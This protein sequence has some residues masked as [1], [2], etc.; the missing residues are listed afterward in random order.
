[1]IPIPKRFQSTPSTQLIRN[2]NRKFFDKY[3][4]TYIPT[5]DIKSM[6]CT[7]LIDADS[8]TAIVG[9]TIT[10]TAKVEPLGI[11]DVN[12]NINGS[13]VNPVPIS[14][15]P[16]GIA[17]LPLDS[18][19]QP[20]GIY[21]MT[22]EVVSPSTCT[23]SVLKIALTTTPCTGITINNSSP[24]NA[25][26]GDIIHA[27]ATAT[28]AQPSIIEFAETTLGRFGS[29]IADPLT[30]ECTVDMDTIGAPPGTYSVVAKVGNG[31]LEQCVSTPVEAIL[32]EAPGKIIAV[33]IP[34]GARIWYDGTDTGITT[35]AIISNVTP[36]V[37]HTIEFKLSG[38]AVY[39]DTINIASGETDGEFIVLEPSTFPTETGDLHVTSTPNGVSFGL[40]TGGTGTAE[41]TLTG[42]PALVNAYEAG[43]T[44]Y[45]SALG[46]V[47]IKPGVITD[48]NIVLQPEIVN[49]GLAIFETIPMGADIYIDGLLTGAKTSYATFLAP[50]SHTYELRLEG[51]PTITGDF[52][53]VTGTDNPAIVSAVLRSE[54]SGI[55]M[56]AGVAVLGMMVLSPK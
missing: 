42:I 16:S 20:S 7:V 50:G 9:Q 15:D 6:Q 53:V 55:I 2:K 22:V 34:P 39:T 8:L 27:S 4:T 43:L 31:T 30:G 38:Y 51:Y 52:V 3:K 40:Y 33:S 11:Y 21:D 23:S 18:T 12:F 41:T 1:M 5:N 37:D 26:I 24:I 19:G 54:S 13:T 28:I 47:I 35:S 46:S 10:L 17:I 36:G 45:S 44:G 48:L 29:C 56:L 49:S 25:N 14:T 32:Q